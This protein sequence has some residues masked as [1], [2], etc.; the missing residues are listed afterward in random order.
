MSKK[1]GTK[2]NEILEDLERRT[3]IRASAVVSR[4]GLMMASAL[5]KD[6]DEDA[7]SAMSAGILSIGT[8]VGQVLKQGG[9]EEVTIKGEKGYT[10]TMGCGSSAVLIATAP[11]D[12]KL[13]MIYFE[14]KSTAKDV[15]SQLE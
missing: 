10:V 9:V 4:D 11:E 15:T 1:L 12:A 7:I 14:M 3:E 13:G 6:V 5:P 2:L 8:R